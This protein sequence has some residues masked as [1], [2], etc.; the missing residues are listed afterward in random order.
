MDSVLYYII[1]GVIYFLFSRLRK[2]EEK[3]PVRPKGKAPQQQP[4]QRPSN[5]NEPA[6]LEDLLGELF[7]EGKPK[8]Q[9]QPTSQQPTSQ[10]PAS[11]QPQQMQPQTMEERAAQEQKHLA[12]LKRKRE[13]AERKR[14]LEN[15]KL[16]LKRQRELEQE[17]KRR[18]AL[19]NQLA[20][21]SKQITTSTSSKK[22]K[23]RKAGQLKKNSNRFSLRDA[24]VAKIILDRPYID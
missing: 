23:K 22:V 13:E 1:I 9:Q 16:A 8:P 19:M 7:N 10:Q 4:Q 5:K 21:S 24:V 15:E 2:K 14:K 17:S 3:P 12:E 11:T 20:E 18:E 6:S